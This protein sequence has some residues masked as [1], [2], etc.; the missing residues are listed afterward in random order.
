MRTLVKDGVYYDFKT[1]RFYS[2]PVIE[3]KRT[4]RMLDV[5][6]LDAAIAAMTGEKIKTVQEMCDRYMRM[7]CPTRT[8]EKRLSLKAESDDL[9]RV[10]QTFGGREVT[11]IGRTDVEMYLKVRCRRRAGDREMQA[12]SN[13][14]NWAV[15]SGLTQS[16]PIMVR[17]RTELTTPVRRSR[18]VMPAN[19]DVLHSIVG[20]LLQHPLS[21]STG[22]LAI[23]IALTGLRVSE[24]IALRRDAKSKSDPGWVEGDYL[25]VRRS[26]RGKFNY[27]R[28]SPELRSALATHSKWIAG[29]GETPWYFPGR[30]LKSRL[31]RTTLVKRLEIVCDRLDVPKVT[32]HGLRAFFVTV[33]RSRGVPDDQVAALIG[34]STASLIA[35]TYGNLPDSW[36]GGPPLS[37][38]PEKVPVCWA[39]V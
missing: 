35:T 10:C 17:P 24:A 18:E 36:A 3:G 32:A 27:V 28:I 16:N 39:Y 15:R 33:M 1:G 25:Y 34:D 14:F 8:G 13:A 38:T 19:A 11:S 21:Q 29:L 4:W 30:D 9:K 6:T 5:E 20:E 23:I 37:F 12:L 26:K 2:R 31:M 22:W 7:G